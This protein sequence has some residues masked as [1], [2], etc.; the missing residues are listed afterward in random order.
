MRDK[1]FEIASNPKYE[2]HQRGLASMVYK[3]FDKKFTDSGVA[4][5]TNK[6]AI[7]SMPNQQLVNELHKA[8]IRKLKKS[9]YSSFKDN[10]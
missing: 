4:K 3:F 6:S 10:I 2:G 1:S 9:V 8:I 5:L 7:I